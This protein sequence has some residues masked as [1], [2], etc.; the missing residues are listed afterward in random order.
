MSRKILLM[1]LVLAGFMLAGCG[2]YGKVEQ[3]TVVAAGK[4]K[5]SIIIDV[6][7]D[8]KKPAN[9]WTDGTPHDYVLPPVGDERGAEPAVGLCVN[10]DVAKKTITMYNPKEKKFETYPIEVIEDINR[11]V[12]LNRRQEVLHNVKVIRKANDFPIVDEAKKTI[13][14][15]YRRLD[16]TQSRLTTIKLAD[17]DFARYQKQEWGAGDEVRIYY[18]KPGV[19]ERFMNITKTDIT[20]R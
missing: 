14:L 5:V 10:L 6:N 19:A 17:A 7:T 8:P 9:Y 13:Q 18:K 2:D 4:D 3:G 20:R 12:R 16:G 1:L 11:G 15:F